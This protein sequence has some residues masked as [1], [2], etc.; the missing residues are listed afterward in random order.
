MKKTFLKHVGRK[1]FQSVKVFFCKVS[2]PDPRDQSLYAV[3]GSTAL[4]YQLSL[5]INNV[6]HT[7]KLDTG[8]SVT[9]LSEAK[10]HQ[11]FSRSVLRNMSVLLTTYSEERIYVVGEMD[12]CV[13]Y[14][15]QAQ[16]L[17]LTAVAGDGL[18]LLVKNWLQKIQLCWHEIQA[19][20]LVTPVVL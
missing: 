10:C 18:S 4:A 3:G 16:D 12:V 2:A 17:V 13:Q 11:L 1:T 15:H 7:M 5:I 9:P 20:I 14:E 19:V 8:A 6:S